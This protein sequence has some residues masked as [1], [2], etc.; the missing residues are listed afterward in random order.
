MGYKPD[1]R[2]GAV[3]IPEAAI[4][5]CGDLLQFRLLCLL[6]SDR[7]LC[8]ADDSVI[9]ERLLCSPEEVR[10]TAEALRAVG[11]IKPE[12]KLAP[13]A[14]TKNLTG[15]EIAEIVDGDDGF[16]GFVNEC[17]NIC[18][19]VFTPIDLSKIAS[20]RR[21]LG[22][23]GET[24]VLMF[25]YYAEKLDAVGKKLS[26]SYV[27]KAAY[28]LF[29]QGV[30]TYPQLQAYIK[31]TEERNTLNYRL[32]RLFG[33]GDRAF[34]KKEKGFFEK[35]SGEWNMPFEMIE[36]SFEITV[37]NTGKPSL[38]YM[39]RILSDWHAEG[40][41][42]VCEAEKRSAERKEAVR[43]KS[44]TKNTAPEAKES[45]FDTDEF[46]EKALKRSYAMLGNTA[47]KEEKR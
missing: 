2:E 24:I 19:K 37:N 35:W 33:M 23:D 42:T 9:A 22:F 39:S 10:A 17:E 4:D 34:T 26:V 29:N 47:A 43:Y 3:A 15:E 20:L 27:E 16:R 14:Q 18:G 41:T 1:F 38:D 8:E 31:T 32:R 46:F 7:T 44:I 36:F 12:K 25:F 11:L 28:S 40:I 13:S 21:D 5:A 6:C 30:R 45:S